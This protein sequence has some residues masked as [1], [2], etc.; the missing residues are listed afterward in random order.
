M[1]FVS[2]SRCACTVQTGT[3]PTTCWCMSQT[4]SVRAHH[5]DT[6]VRA[7]AIEN[8]CYVVAANRLG[9]DKNGLHYNGHSAI[10][11]P[12][13]EQIAFSGEENRTGCHRL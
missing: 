3:T 10:I 8:Q 11:G 7:R 12:Q 13:G 9:E 2:R 5:W 6:L 4:A 1:T